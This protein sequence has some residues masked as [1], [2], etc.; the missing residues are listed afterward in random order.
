MECPNL[1]LRMVNV[2]RGRVGNRTY[3]LLGIAKVCDKFC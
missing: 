2:E 3:T 1:E